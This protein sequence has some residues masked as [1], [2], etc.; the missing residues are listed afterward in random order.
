MVDPAFLPLCCG[1]PGGGFWIEVGSDLASQNHLGF[2]PSVTVVDDVGCVDCGGRNEQ[3][4]FSRP[5]CEPACDIA[6]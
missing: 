5:M 2:V 6:I 3:R 4:A 1:L